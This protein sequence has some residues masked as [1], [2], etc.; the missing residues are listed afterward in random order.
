MKGKGA[1]Q[2]K[3]AVVVLLPLSRLFSRENNISQQKL[4]LACTDTVSLACTTAMYV[5]IYR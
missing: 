5:A 1:K 3:S 2:V 4:F